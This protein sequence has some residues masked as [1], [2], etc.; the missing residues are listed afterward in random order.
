MKRP[1]PWPSFAATSRPCGPFTCR[2]C[3]PSAPGPWATP[4]TTRSAT[5]S[6]CPRPRPTTG[7]SP[8]WPLPSTIGWWFSTTWPRRSWSWRWPGSIGPGRRSSRPTTT[9]GGGSMPWSS[10]WPR[11]RPT[12]NWSIS[13]RKARWTWNTARISRGSSSRRR[14]RSA[15]STFAPATSSRSCSA[16]GWRCRSRPIPSRS[17]APCGSSIP[18]PSCSTSARPA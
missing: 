3:R 15:W 16:S 6:G 1:I 14:S 7:R 9:P 13:A 17:T 4:V 8:T 5:S 10:N 2:N 11:A 12:W 18:A